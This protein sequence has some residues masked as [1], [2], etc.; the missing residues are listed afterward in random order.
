MNSLVF[1]I[2]SLLMLIFGGAVQMSG[3]QMSFRLPTYPQKDRDLGIIQNFLFFHAFSKVEKD[4]KE[5][6]SHTTDVEGQLFIEG[7]TEKLNGLAIA[8]G[9]EMERFANEGIT[10][11][12]FLTS[13]EAYLS[14]LEESGTLYEKELAGEIK[15]E[16]VEE[17][18]GTL[19]PIERMLKS[20]A[21]YKTPL[22]FRLV[23][24]T[25]NYELY[26]Q[27]PISADD[28]HNIAKLIKK[29]ADSGYWELLKKKGEM[30]K[31]GDRIMPLH[32]MRFLGFIFSN[33]SL[34]KR[35]PKI[36]DATLKRRGFLNG[37]GNREGF[38]QR[39]TK[40]AQ[41]QN[42]M[43]YLPGFSQAI[44]VTQSSIEPYFHRHDWEGLLRFLM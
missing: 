28:Q 5:G 15:W 22:E 1:K 6:C 12:D 2:L 32:P 3:A 39:M 9:A 38:A 30:D 27:L 34:K 8:L 17:I 19:L 26:Y 7:G 41:N 35:M 43:Q 40:E 18:K 37:H 25:L 13:K 33:P 42:L 23:N 11:E 44:G 10:Q 36:M 24:G 16:D 14:S 20:L 21:P 31:L 29:M 4:K